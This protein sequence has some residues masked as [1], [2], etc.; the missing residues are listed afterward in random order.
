[1]AIQLSAIQVVAKASDAAFGKPLVTNVLRSLL[2]EAIVDTALGGSWNWCSSD[3]A[4]HDF[5]DS[6]GTRLEVKQSAARQSWDPSP[7]RKAPPTFDIAP[8]TGYWIGGTQWVPQAGRNADIYVLAHH[9]IDDDTA[10]HRE[11]L[12]W[13]FYVVATSKLP[14]QKT[15]SLNRVKALAQVCGYDQLAD[16]VE[17]VRNG[18]G[19]GHNSS[20]LVAT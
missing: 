6:N 16:E 17:D 2:V 7:T 10:D 15:I 20:T 8:R 14:D 13:H 4:S 11:P 1:M 12:Q 9:P 19:V 5:V 18:L 3:Y